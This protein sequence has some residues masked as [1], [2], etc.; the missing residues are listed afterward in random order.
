[1]DS[2]T[3]TIVNY[4]EQTDVTNR[5]DLLSVARIAFLDYLASLAPAENKQ[6]V[7]DLARFI[8]AKSSIGLDVGRHMN[9]SVFSGKVISA[10]NTGL[11][12]ENV[13][14][15][16][17]ALYYGF[18]SHYLDSD[19]AQANLAGH[20]ST[21][22]YSALLAVLEPTDTWHEFFRA[23]IIGAELEG[24][25]GSLINP[26][27]RTQGWH[28]TG[29][30][31]VI[32]A[33][34]AI[35]ALRGLHGESLAQLL[36]LAATQSAGMFFQS[37]T[38]GKPL[39][40]GLAARNGVWAYELLQH[41]SL[42]TSTKPFDPERGWFKTIGNITVTSND[43]A[44]RW[45]APGQLIDPGLWM[46]VHPYCSAAI[47]GAEAAEIVAH[48]LYTSDSFLWD[49]INRVTVHFPP[50]AD[51]ALRY[52]L[53]K[54]GR[55]GQ[56]SIEYVVYQVLAYGEVQD[57][58]FKIDAIDQSVRDCMSRIE[59]VYDLPKVSQTERITKVTV[60]LKNGDTFTETV[61]NPKG[62]PKN[63]L[64]MEDIRIKLGLTLEAD[65]IDRVI[66][67]FTNTDK[68]ES[69]LQTLRKEGV[70]HV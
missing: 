4:I 43:I 23:Y 33:A 2:V 62:S 36:S 37:G 9:S 54:T 29:T 6:A 24:I 7:R 22:L 11:A 44:S 10:G 31:G 45:L 53:P 68:V 1:M 48:R 35:G 63:P 40:A 15:V 57:E 65:Q 59:R 18:A 70:L 64:T 16:D 20:F 34:A 38:D 5:E 58:L 8:G 3:Q 12:I 47:C 21:V 46:K 55:E 32:G 52:T 49:E 61:N 26:A 66:V 27:H 60:T 25:I 69:F 41:T 17:K 30:V 14:K 50:G 67:A 42:R 13:S 19:D 28:S 51:A 39:H 56:F